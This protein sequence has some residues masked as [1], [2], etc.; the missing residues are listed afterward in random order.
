MDVPAKLQLPNYPV[1]NLQRALKEKGFAI[2]IDGEFN[3]ETK[4]ALHE[5]QQANDLP[6][7]DEVSDETWAV[8]LR[9]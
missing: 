2:E 1:L 5:V 6:V 3:E 7:T 9:E 8:L 4:Q